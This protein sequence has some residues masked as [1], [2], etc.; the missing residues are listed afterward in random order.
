MY[1][2]IRINLTK[3]AGV[4]SLNSENSVQLRSYSIEKL[5]SICDKVGLKLTH[6]RLEIFKELI[7]SL[8]HP[9]AEVIYERLKKT[10]P[11]IAID[12]VYRTLATFSD[13]GLVKKLNIKNKPTLFDANL[14]QHHH[15]I[16]TRC[17][18]VHDLYWE[19]FDNTALPEAAK[20]LGQT[21]SRHLELHGICNK[22]LKEQGKM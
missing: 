9:T 22:C 17:K 3:G 11:T 18:T 16:C 7:S 15:F 19:K 20:H 13:L 2:L 5:K 14:D 4:N 1:S 10:L 8:D 6:Q 12:T 21:K